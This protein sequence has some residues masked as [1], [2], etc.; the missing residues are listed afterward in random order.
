MPA[1]AAA[2]GVGMLTPS[3]PRHRGIGNDSGAAKGTPM[4][5]LLKVVLWLVGGL[6][7]LVVLFHAEE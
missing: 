2:E 7:A 4:K 1:G 6:V 5:K 3:A